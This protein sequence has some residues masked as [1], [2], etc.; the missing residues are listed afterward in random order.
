MSCGPKTQASCGAATEIDTRK[1]S[2]CEEGCFCPEGTVLHDGQC[3]S[4]EECPCKLRSKQFRPGSTTSKDCNTCTC[5]SGKWVC[6]QAKCN[7]RC[8]AVGDPH[9]TTFDGK[10]YDFMGKCSYYLVKGENYTI[11]G[12]NVACPGAL[13]EVN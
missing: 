3:I 10:R 8:A 9:Y 12:E 2:E 5:S 11:E 1:G 6:T 7:A 4:P 13:S